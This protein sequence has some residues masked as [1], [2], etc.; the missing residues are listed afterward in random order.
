[1]TIQ[2]MAHG[3]VL[4]KRTYQKFMNNDTINYDK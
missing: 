1:M 3:V 4:N 2:I